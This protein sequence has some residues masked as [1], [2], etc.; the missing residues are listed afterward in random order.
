MNDRREA[1][2]QNR[3]QMPF[4]PKD[5]AGNDKVS[6]SITY[7]QPTLRVGKQLFCTKT[8][9]ELKVCSECKLPSAGQQ[10]AVSRFQS[11]VVTAAGNVKPALS[12]C[13]T[14]SVKPSH[15]GKSIAQLPPASRV[16]F[17]YALSFMVVSAVERG[18]E[19]ERGLASI[20]AWTP[21]HHPWT[22][23]HRKPHPMFDHR[24]MSKLPDTS[25]SQPLR[26]AI[27]GMGGIGST[28]AFQLA[29]IGHHNV[30]AIARPGSPRLQQ[31][32]RDGG[33]V[34][35]KGERAK[36][37]VDD[38][39]DENVA[40]DLVLVTLP[41]HQVEAVLRALERSAATWIQF[42]FNTFDPERLQA[43]VGADRCSFGM[44]F[45]QGSIDSD[46]K[47]NA[48]IGAGGQK[49]IM[50]NQVWVDVFSASGLPG[51]LE[52]AMLLWLR[53]HVPM[54]IA[55]ESVSVAGMRRGGGASWNEAM[56][57]AHGMKESLMLIRHLGYQIYPA[58][59]A[60]LDSSPAFV[61]ASMLWFISH[62]PSFRK[63]LATGINECRALVDVLVATAPQANSAVAFTKIRA[64][65]PMDH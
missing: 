32:K 29:R 8:L 47:L 44:P 31:L 42:M 43:A 25:F 14:L 61:T 28:F 3:R 10:K 18:S 50:N 33:V 11:N 58:G 40:Y 4:E 48:K 17:R 63:L 60:R 24:L 37:Q 12:F 2:E 9:L 56:V 52:P 15:E 21:E 1:A 26:I 39:L 38:H 7:S 20:K 62:V 54:C 35:V 51:K 53:C 13:T 16:T 22:I 27:V 23:A 34:N 59:K 30:T 41:A 65:K 6:A 46:G 64:M 57:I 19:F 36:L 45:V 49:S 5:R 55:F